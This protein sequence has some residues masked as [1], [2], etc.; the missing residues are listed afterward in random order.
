MNCVKIK[1]GEE[2]I[3]YTKTVFSGGEVH[4]QLDMSEFTPRDS[5][6]SF[7]ATLTAN[8]TSAQDIME[9]LLVANALRQF[10]Y[11]YRAALSLTLEIPYFPYARQDRVCATG[12]AFSL[13]VM[14]QIINTINIQVLRLYDVHSEAFFD[15][16]DLAIPDT[17]IFNYEASFFIKKSP[18]LLGLLCHK[19]TVIICPDKGALDRC[20]GVARSCKLDAPL[21]LV[22]C[23][24]TRDPKTGDITDTVVPG[25]TFK[26]KTAVIID[27][28]CDG[29]YTFIKIAEEL[30]RK[31]ADRVVL[32]VTHGIF[33]KGLE[34]FEGI[35]DKV[36]TTDSIIKK[37]ATEEFELQEL[38]YPV[39]TV[40]KGN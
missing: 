5:D 15:I 8:L 39:L 19:D 3:S 34:V 35:I 13:R 2:E 18:E 11:N 23:S 14:C 24:K 21:P 1:Y 32:Y 16:A 28:I 10:N 29:G 12:Q 20:S 7:K 9:L 6:I 31:G 38:K 27:D 25:R 17:T 26:G 30:K 22:I 33:S 40:I 37:A 4:V 36:Y